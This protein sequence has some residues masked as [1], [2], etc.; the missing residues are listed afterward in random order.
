MLGG[1]RDSNVVQAVVD[2]PS[3]Q[4]GVETSSSKGRTTLSFSLER[5][6]PLPMMIQP[7]A[8]IVRVGFMGIYKGSLWALRLNQI[9][10]YPIS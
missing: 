2:H 3:N 8:Q 9:A 10:L 1:G 6:A 7:A 4:D 5:A